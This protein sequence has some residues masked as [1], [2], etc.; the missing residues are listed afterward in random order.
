[1][2]E[3]R[4][5]ISL[6]LNKIIEFLKSDRIK[7]AESLVYDENFQSVLD[8]SNYQDLE[9]N[10]VAEINRFVNEIKDSIGAKDSV[11]GYFFMC[12]K[13]ETY[14]KISYA[15]KFDRMSWKYLAEGREVLNMIGYRLKEVLDEGLEIINS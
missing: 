8:S 6:I 15:L 14:F 2:D 1:M 5:L 13:L 10:W 7:D 3:S 11:Y 4:E 12:S 9:S